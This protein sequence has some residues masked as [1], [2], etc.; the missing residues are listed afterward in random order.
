MVKFKPDP[1]SSPDTPPVRRVIKLPP[2]FYQRRS[3]SPI[4][5][6]FHRNTS[7]GAAGP[8]LPTKLREVHPGFERN[9]A[10]T[11]QKQSD[12]EPESDDSADESGEA[13][14]SD[15][16]PEPPRRRPR[17][18]SGLHKGNTERYVMT[19]AKYS[20]AVAIPR[21]TSSKRK[22]GTEKRTLHRFSNEEH[23][24][25]WFYRNDLECSRGDTYVHFNEY[26][27][28]HIRKDS[29]A[30]T[31]ERLRQKRPAE[32]CEAQHTEP[33]AVGESYGTLHIVLT[34]DVALASSFWLRGKLGAPFTNE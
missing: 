28:L 29:I 15:E 22:D 16:P 20:P 23:R 31:Y 2:R 18:Q 27:G 17:A 14:T 26:F 7:G 19:L 1:A 9:R 4:E 10:E 24:F 8:F 11:Q 25:I 32:I 21:T 34:P 33:W 5:P 6:V 13:E 30:N 3:R 12:S